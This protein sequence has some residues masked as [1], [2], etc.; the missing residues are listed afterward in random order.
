MELQHVLNRVYVEKRPKIQDLEYLLSLETLG[1][2]EV[3]FDFA[4]RVRETHMG[5]GILLRGIVEFSNHC[6]N[7]CRYCGL[8]RFQDN[9]ERFRM[10]AEEVLACVRDIDE[11]GIKTVVLQS[12]E[13]MGCDAAW[14]AELVSE[15]KARF[16]VAVTLSVGERAPEDYGLWRRAGADRYLLKIETMNPELYRELHPEMSHNFRLACLGTLAAL[17]YQ[18]GSGSIVGVKGQSVRDL[19]EDIIF[20]SEGGFSMLGIGPFIPHS[21][22][23]MGVEAPGELNL[24]LKMLAVTRIVT[25]NTHLPATTA[26]GS[27]AGRAAWKT[28]LRAGANVVMPN[29]TPPPYRRCYDVYPDR[30]RV[31]ESP[32]ACVRTIESIAR[33]IQRKV[34]FSRGDS[35]K[36]NQ[37]KLKTDADPSYNRSQG[38]E[39]NV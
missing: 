9:L 15:I 18:T 2:R 32:K 20:F 12:G 3:L 10:S 25:K 39:K 16:S 4:D 36:I 6:R 31:A 23:D 35:L 11:A 30:D 7:T 27:S 38:G 21:G 29:F 14:L 37:G 1:E 26:L 8:N 33:S 17:G 34:D 22:T 19:A 28:A 24:A 13:D 5:R